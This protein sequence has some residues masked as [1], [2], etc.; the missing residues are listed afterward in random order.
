MSWLDIIIL[1]PLLIGLIV[2]L[3]K[4]LVEEITSIAALLLGALG[5]K[6]WGA[7]LATWLLQQFEW[8]DT[9][10]MIVAYAVLFF[11]IALMLH[12]LAKLLSKLFQKISLGWLNR[13][14]GGVFG[15][16]KWAFIMLML[17][18]CL[19]RLDCQFHFFKDE[20]KQSS[21][22]YDRVT[23]LSEQVWEKLK[24]EITDK[25][26]EIKQLEPQKNEQK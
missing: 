13:M 17:V 9:I 21:L 4:G 19:H 14:L 20:L 22:L 25:M 5:A 18:L 6:L 1:L 3:M 2:G 12:V 11:G 23:P 16:L 15:M 8:S 24:A 26:E 7:T 10:C